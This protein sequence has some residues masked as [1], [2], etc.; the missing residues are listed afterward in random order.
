MSFIWNTFGWLNH[1]INLY[2]P[3]LQ[4]AYEIASSRDGRHETQVD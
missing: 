2:P 1:S 4:V 3:R